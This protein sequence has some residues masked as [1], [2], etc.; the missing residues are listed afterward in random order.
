MSSRVSNKLAHFVIVDPDGTESARIALTPEG[1]F[2]WQPGL[3]P[4]V[5]SCVISYREM[6]KLRAVALERK[7]DIGIS[8]RLEL[9][10][11]NAKA[12]VVIQKV[13]IVDSQPLTLQ[14]REVPGKTLPIY[15]SY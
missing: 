2:S 13:R 8:G 11:A 7:S 10:D 3:K 12:D 6:D 5:W 1:S 4:A 15:L 9:Q 14:L